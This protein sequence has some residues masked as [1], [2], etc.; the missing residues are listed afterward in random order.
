MYDPT[1]AVP[2][3]SASLPLSARPVI[4]PEDH[5]AAHVDHQRPEREARPQ[6]DATAPS[7]TKRRTDPQPPISTTPA[8]T[9]AMSSR[10]TH[11]RRTAA[12][13]R[14]MAR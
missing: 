2:A 13:A 10:R 6:P 8:H 11:T 3:S 9:S 12:V 5:G 7:T 1:A 14:W 4:K